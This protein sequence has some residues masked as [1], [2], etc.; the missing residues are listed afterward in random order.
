MDSRCQNEIQGRKLLSFAYGN[1]YDREQLMKLMKIGAVAVLLTP[2][3]VFAASPFDGTWKFSPEHFRPS[4]KP[5][6]LLLN[7][8]DFTCK[9]C[10]SSIHLKPDGSVHP[11]KGDSNFDSGTVLVAD[12]QNVTLTFMLSGKPVDSFKYVIAPDAKSMVVEQSATY[13]A[14]PTVYKEK[15]TRV[16]DVPAGV[17]ALSGSW[18]FVK[19]L[20]VAGPGLLVTYGMTADGF[21]MSSNGQ[22]YDAK[23]DDKT[24]PVK[25]DPTKTV[26]NLKKVS[27][28]EV[29]ES[30]SQN[31]KVVE[32]FDLTVAADGKSLHVVD[33]DVPVH[34]VSTYTMT[35]TP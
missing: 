27:D 9:S 33:T 4:S 32:T 22:S 19:F 2:P 15:L 8:E 14:E 16:G 30:D 10:S 6:V 25:G 23:F 21:T 18:K 1:E 13:G 3:A 7:K 24:Y 31:G 20:S 35:K 12:A 28:S 17:H 11:I 26:V 34:H 5:L 29:I